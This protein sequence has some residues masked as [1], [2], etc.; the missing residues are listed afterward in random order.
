[1]Q[2]EIYVKSIVQLGITLAMTLAMVAVGCPSQTASGIENQR[3]TAIAQE[4]R[5]NYAEAETAWRACLKAHPANAEAYAHLGFLEA[6]QERYAEAVP[7]Y[8]RAFALNP[9]MPSL[10]LNL[11][12][13]LFK[14][15]ALKDA[16]QILIP[17]LKQEPSSSSEAQRLEVLIGMSHYGL[18]EYA[19]AIPYLK[20]AAGADP[21]NIWLRLALAQ[22]CLGSKKFQCVLDVYHEIIELNAESAEADML[23]GEALDEMK[24]HA[25]AIQQFRAAAKA[26]PKMPNVHFVLGYLLWTQNQLEE[27]AQEFQ[28]ELT[29]VPN[30]PEVLTYLADVDI[31]LSNPGA[32]QPLLEE[33]I[34]I[35]PRIALAHLDLGIIYADADRKSDAL[36]E[37]K[38][39]EQL[40]PNDTNVHWRLGRFYQAGGEKGEAKAEFDKTRNLQKAADEMIFKKLH[41]GQAKGKPPDEVSS[42]PAVN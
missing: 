40:D 25:G 28:A 9:E 3:Q 23:A 22:S 12:L 31:K 24:D 7:L 34:R 38:I 5:G 13:S 41:E 4:Q 14:S 32:A 15:G 29:N 1:M 26:D 11:G 33:A 19:A 8:R 2:M 6:R 18:G 16:I 21:Q 30:H 42:S 35:D 36:R 20:K 39:A 17:L 37:M 27:A 10:R